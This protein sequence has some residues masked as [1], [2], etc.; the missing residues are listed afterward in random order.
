MA[1]VIYSE[2][3]LSTVEIIQTLTSRG[4]QI[5]SKE[6][7][8]H[9]F[10]HISYFRLK[11]YLLPLIQDKITGAFKKGASLEDAYMLYKFDSALRKLICAELEKIEISLRTVVSQELSH[12]YSPYWFSESALFSNKEKHSKILSGISAELHR[13]DDDQILD[14]KNKYSNDFPPSWMTLEVSSFGTLSLLFKHLNGGRTK[15]NIANYYGVAD[16]VLESWIHSFVYVRNI[17]AHHSRLWNKTLRVTGGFPKKTSHA[18]IETR[19]PNDKVYYVLCIIRYML[20]TINPNSSF[21]TR[22]INL[23]QDYPSVDTRAMGFPVNWQEEPLW[24][25]ASK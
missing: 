18:F 12:T 9:I 11:S 23:L 4:L 24:Q 2:S 20:L 17:C 14:F 16:T 8:S 15:R 7:A 21:T 3:P 1:K 5:S 22:L 6:K 25:I 10:G 13:S 19:V